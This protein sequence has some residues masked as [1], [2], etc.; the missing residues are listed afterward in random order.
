M[1]GIRSVEALTLLLGLRG[2]QLHPTHCLPCTI[3]SLHSTQTSGPHP[4]LHHHPPISHLLPG[5]AVCLQHPI[6]AMESGARPSILTHLQVPSQRP[7]CTSVSW[8]RPGS[9]GSWFCSWS[10][11]AL[12]SNLE[13]KPVS[14]EEKLVWAMSSGALSSEFALY[15]MQWT[16][17]QMCDIR[18]MSILLGS[19]TSSCFLPS[20]LSSA[21]LSIGA[22]PSFPRASP[23]RAGAPTSFLLFQVFFLKAT[24]WI[25]PKHQQAYISLVTVAWNL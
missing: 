15:S 18:V 14:L 11:L 5:H 8:A 23:S 7:P 25:F 12:N 24:R 16:F 19:P 22:S 9:W 6:S 17:A 2:R 4:L 13:P 1:V 3:C 20:S 21:F 10:T